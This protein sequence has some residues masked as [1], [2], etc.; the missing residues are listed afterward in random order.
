MVAATNLP[1]RT[2]AGSAAMM[3]LGIGAVYAAAAV[4]LFFIYNILPAS[5]RQA[6]QPPEIANLVFL[7]YLPFALRALWA[8]LVDR[9]GRQRAPVYRRIVLICL[10]LS[11]PGIAALLAFSP[12]TGPLWI[13]LAATGLIGLIATATIGLDGYLMAM[14]PAAERSRSAALQGGAFALGGLAMG[15]GILACDDAAWTVVVWLLMAIMAGFAIPALAL[16]ATAPDH[17]AAE[18]GE[19]APAEVAHFLV[20]AA[21]WRL[22]GLSAT[23]HAGLALAGGALPVLQVDAGLSLGQIALVSAAGAN[24]VGLLAAWITGLA[25]RRLGGW[26]VAVLLGITAT[27]GFLAT[28]LGV[29]HVGPV[30]AI[31]MSLC[32]MALGYGFFVTFRALVLRRCGGPLGATQAASL[33]SL[34]ALVATVFAI[35]SGLVIGRY[36][37]PVLLVLSALLCAAGAALAW[38]SP[39][40]TDPTA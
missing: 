39:R 32:V 37:L 20:S 16:P 11:V 21:S 38:R 12:A 9:L 27:L 26:P 17:P 4:P 33:A 2:D 31:T 25:M 22:I 1:T 15:I 40:E 23:L 3:R 24:G 7:A 28:A 35:L 6:G 10:G 34:D 36:G 13:T 18:R 14:L 5:L 30:T 29:G 8:P 19:R